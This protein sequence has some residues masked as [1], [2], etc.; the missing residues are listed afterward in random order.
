M[1]T[2]PQDPEQNKA[3]RIAWYKWEFL[4]RNVEY[5]KDYEEFIREFG[6]WFEEHGY[7][8]DET[9]RPWGRGNLR[10]FATVIAPKAKAICERWAVGDL[11]SPNWKFTRS[12]VHTYRRGWTV[13][14]PT[15]CSKEQEG[16]GVDLP[17]F[18][19]FD[20]EFE[21]SLPKYVR[22]AEH[23]LSLNLDLRQPLAALLGQAREQIAFLK[24]QYDRRHPQPAKLSAE[25]R[26]R[27]DLY[28]KYLRVWDL[29][30]NGDK[31]DYIGALIF[32][33][34][35]SPLQSA[36]DARRTAQRLIDGGY[37]ELT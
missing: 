33:D 13:F 20:E 30:E 17:Q 16:Q 26:T 9:I 21:K 2:K 19:L 22:P 5:R 28:G 3:L 14:L 31:F 4:R 36:K 37:K 25:V 24:A 15:D 10:F 6:S 27:L 29:K 12:G 18:Y 8:Y 23:R 35:R 7:W 34:K 32:S 11:F 1:P